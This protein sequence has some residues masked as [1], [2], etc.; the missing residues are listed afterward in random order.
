MLIACLSDIHDR[1]EN[2]DRA[3]TAISEHRPEALICCG[4]LSQP[5]VLQRMAGGFPGEIHTVLGNTDSEKDIKRVI[6]AER[7][8]K[9]YYHQLVGR[10]T[11]AKRHIAF[12][13]KPKDAEKL[14][15]EHRFDVV[16]YGHTHEASVERRD[17]TLFVNPGDL[18][19]R[20]G[21]TPSYALYDTDPSEAT[22]H[23][24][25]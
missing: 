4:D 21:N 23:E 3:L 20:F 19:G 15:E 22:L 6:G 24:I 17:H 25:T 11:F 2:L 5:S 14:L 10:L 13:H 12:T 7:L 8:L 9:V 16:F 18:Q 1:V